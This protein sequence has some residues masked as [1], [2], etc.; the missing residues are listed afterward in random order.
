MGSIFSKLV[1]GVA[2]L[3][4]AT[5][6]SSS[7]AA[8]Q[9]NGPFDV[10]DEL[11]LT[12]EQ[13]RR[14]NIVSAAAITRTIVAHD[15]AIPIG[16]VPE[17]TSSTIAE[18][19]V[20]AL[21][22][23][24][25]GM[26]AYLVAPDDVQFMPNSPDGCTFRLDLPQSR[27]T[28]TNNLG[29][30]P[31]L[32]DDF[33]WIPDHWPTIR[34]R[35]ISFGQLGM[36]VIFHANTDVTLS[37]ESLSAGI[38]PLDES[39][40]TGP[41]FVPAG[42]HEVVWRAE[43]L[44]F[45]FF[46][47]ILPGAMM[48]LMMG[49][50][51]KFAKYLDDLVS[52]RAKQA[53]YI[54]G[55]AKENVPALIGTLKNLNRRINVVQFINKRLESPVGKLLG[56]GKKILSLDD[57]HD[58]F[59]VGFTTVERARTQGLTVYDIYQPTISTTE[60]IVDLEATD[61][62]GVTYARYAYDLA[63]TVEASDSC[64]RPIRISNDAPEFLPLGQTV[65][66]WTVSDPGPAIPGTDRDGDGLDD[67]V[68][69]NQI[70][71]TINVADTQAPI[72]VAPPGLV[73]ELAQGVSTPV[74]LASYD[75]GQPLVVDLVDLDPEVSNS[76]PDPDGQIEVD[77]RTVITWTTTDHAATP[78]VATAD[79]L[80]T[81]KSWNTN[82]PP[83]ADTNSVE[84]LTAKPVDIVL[85]ASDAD[86]LPYSHDPLGP[87]FPDPLQFKIESQPQNGEF[88]SP[89]LPFFINDY[90]TDEVGA[91]FD[92]ASNIAARRKLP[93][94]NPPTDDEIKAV[95]DD[96]IFA[97]NTNS[98]E[99]FLNNEFC[100][101]S[102]DAPLGFVWEPLYTQV[103]DN[104]EQYFF[105]QYLVCDP[106][107]NGDPEWASYY[108]ISRWGPGGDFMG[109]VRV[110]DNGGGGINNDEAVFDI[111]DEGF[112]YFVNS[113][114][115]GEAV[116][117]IQRCSAAL[118]SVAPNPG[119]CQSQGFG[120]VDADRVT[121]PDDSNWNPQNA[122]VDIDRELVYVIA[123][124]TIAVFDYRR[125]V[126]DNPNSPRR[127]SAILDW[128]TNDAG[129]RAVLD[130]GICAGPGNPRFR[131]TMEV[132]SQGN[133][134]VTDIE[135]HR[136][137]KFSP[138]AFDA[139]GVFVMGEYIGW[140]G[141]CNQS[142]NLACDVDEQRT[143]GFS[144]TIAAAC[145]VAGGIENGDAPGQF[146]TPAFLAIDPNDILYVADYD[147]SRIQRFGTDG[148]F[149]GQAVSTGNGINA[150][151]DGG[152]VLGNMGPPKHVSV[153]SKNFYV[154]D[155]SEDFVHVFDTSP[156]KN[157]SSS[158]ATVTYVS[159]FAFH[160]AIDT[161]TYS[162]N[163]GLVDSAVVQ[164]SIDVARNYRQ[165]QPIAQT[166]EALED[167]S[168]VIVLQGSDPDGIV[169][170]D[171]NGLDSL[172]FSISEQPEFG[173]LVRGGDPGD[174]T[175]DPGMDVWTYTPDSD[176]FG[177]DTLSFTVRD[178]FTDATDDGGTQIPEPYTEAEAAIV[179]INI[180]AVNDVPVV[181]LDPPERVAAGFPIMLDGTVFDDYGLDHTASVAWGDGT[182]DVLGE[183]LV[184]NNGTPNDSS[185]DS[186][187]FD[188]V[189]LNSESLI[190]IGRSRI[191][192]LHTYT[193]TGPRSIRTCVQDDGHLESCRSMEITVESLAM[194]GIEMTLDASDIKDGIVFRGAIEIAN[195]IPA[196]GVPGL[197][198]QNLVLEM[199]IPSEVVV[200][201]LNSPNGSCNIAASVL[202]CDFGT[203]ANGVVARVDLE[204]RGSGALFYDSEID[205]FAEVRTDT[206]SIEDV[207]ISG[208]T[209]TLRA[210]NLDRD[211][212]GMSNIFEGVTGVTEP[213]ADDDGDGL[214]NLEEFEAGTSPTDADSDGDG[215][216]DGDELN[217]F[218]SDPLE[219]DSDN[220]GISDSDE[221]NIYGSDPATSDTDGD[222]L[223]DNWEVDNGFDPLFADSNGD[224]DGDGLTDEDEYANETDYLNPDTDGDTLSD[225]DEVLVHN[226][227]PTLVD[228]DA[229]GL[230]DN[231]EIA[232]MTNPN[233]PDSDDDDLYD[234]TE[235]FITA[236]LPLVNDTDRDGLGD[237]YE[238][239]SGRNPLLA[240]Y[241]LA[242]GGLSTCALTDSGVECWGLDDF[243]QAPAVVAGLNDP[244]QIAVG[245][246]HACAI[247]RDTG[248]N[249]S[250]LCWG[251]NDFG[252]STAPALVDPVQIV[253][254][255]YHT[256]A[257]D[258]TAPDTT[259]V[260]CWGRNDTFSQTS[261]P[262]NIEQPLR[263]VA[264]ISGNSSC[265]LDDKQSGAELVCWG[266]YNNG[267]STLPSVGQNVQALAHGSEHGC[268]ID[269]GQQLCWGLND[270]GQAPPGP[271][272]KNAVELSLGGFHSC[273]LESI[274]HN[275]Y[276]VDCWGR[277]ADLQTD[278]PDNLTAPISL[279]SGSHH[280][281]SFDSG[282]ARCWGARVNWDRGQAP[283]TRSLDIDPDGDGLRSDAEI[284]AGT[285]PLDPDSDGDGLNDDV[286]I[287]LLTNPN[288]T[289]SDDDGLSDG[290]EVLTYQSDPLSDDT[291]GDGMDDEWEVDHGLLVAADD[292]A[293]DADGDG[294]DNGTEYA[295]GTDPT[296]A[297]TDDD[298]ID[299][300][301]ELQMALDPT[302]PDTDGDGTYDG[303]EVDNGFD[304]LD[305]ADSLLDTDGDGSTNFDEFVAG[306]NP[307]LIDT[308][309]DGMPDG[310]EID[311]DLDPLVTDADG[312]LD[313]DGLS[314]LDEY[315]SGA[316]A[317]AD[318][319][320][321][322]LT[323]PSDVL[324]DSIG[325][326]TNVNIGVAAAVDIR[327]GA[328]AATASDAGPFPPGPNDVTWSAAD[329]SGNRVEASQAVGVVPLVDFAIGQIVDEGDS[330]VVPIMLNGTAVD[331]PVQVN[332]SVLG[333]ATN[334][335]D[336][337]A[338]AGT[339]MI[340]SG[341]TA[342]IPVNIVLD[343]F[344]EGEESFTLSFVEIVNAVPGAQ[345]SHTVTITQSNVK[346]VATITATQRNNAIT[347][348]VSSQGPI[349]IT[350]TVSDPNTSDT[351]LLDWSASDSGIFDPAASTASSYV[352][353]PVTVNP[354]FYRIV[355]DIIDDGAPPAV[356]RIETLL[357]IVATAPPLDGGVDT[358]GDGIDDLT[359]GFD[360]SDNDRVPDYLDSNTH[361]ENVIPYAESS[362]V[363][364]TQPGLK[365]RLGE[366]AFRNGSVAGISEASVRE[367][368]DVGFPDLVAD[369]EVLGVE[370]GASALVVIPMRYALPGNA[371][372]RKFMGG[373][374]QDFVIDSDN[375][376]STAAGTN[377]ACPAPGDLVYTPGLNVG[378]G[379]IQVEIEDGG[380]NDTDGLANGIIRDPSGPAV[381][382]SVRL[383]ASPLADAASSR[384]SSNV[385]VLAFSLVSDSGDTE[386]SGLT[387]AASG[388]GDDMSV[389]AIRLV[390]DENQNG[391]VDN[392]EASIGEGVFQSDNGT[393]DIRMATPYTVAPGRT[394][395]LVTYD[396]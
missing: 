14:R 10:G 395:F 50:E 120:P 277:N 351:H 331:Y 143:K 74:N 221:V 245:F 85:T 134:Y 302:E 138:S 298:G 81:V 183:I 190:S 337:D 224:P 317:Y 119:Y 259:Q 4:L 99:T 16:F 198:A 362:F 284:A 262:G 27:T 17:P 150:N 388:S 206:P 213:D 25:K 112:V 71:Q 89:L 392:G 283:D 359:E 162:V 227:N 339:V 121:H 266:Q 320:P 61:I 130:D 78:N 107:G 52:G 380:P 165:P 314:N 218:G 149:A 166:V 286:E 157:I 290:A 45:P 330:I 174:I 282:A 300:A 301:T 62:G 306:T 231:D 391:I 324:A 1:L 167:R 148:L 127:S 318:D 373:G 385:V 147:N 151:I 123:G 60:P 341:V 333:S 168:V 340:E 185:D 353:D 343:P 356:N 199:E 12:E 366:T 36:P 310:W 255:E 261:V 83:L 354:G 287:Q 2:F 274:T 264:G 111:D 160:S 344:F 292:A 76:S 232:A 345:T 15:I 387:L 370:P 226:S 105:D 114:T 31:R 267:N 90:R 48:P 196:G 169:S 92:E 265:V 3:L 272:A 352:I 161:F 104:G 73:I 9:Y 42:N 367:D 37:L 66:T 219:T 250:V 197:D 241:G 233:K 79:Q 124:P 311:N 315:L 172:T 70:T 378:D 361:G 335:D 328:V 181:R 87:V 125:V 194:V 204:M 184:D 237:G 209:L 321:P 307:R 122:L 77:T 383:E 263:L 252:Q 65:V 59:G 43:T 191:N 365:L 349:V 140:M 82:T 97:V 347:T 228:T 152:F 214:S 135:C 34:D 304:P 268:L 88:E 322:V 229:D 58:R 5:T 316:S 39:Q 23:L 102:I 207:A 94:V 40:T 246:V 177:N 280:S 86:L 133:L 260:I 164:V 139:E 217:V 215:I 187:S 247:D 244:E 24:L 243:G 106:N 308:D 279:A 348:A 68:N 84:T 211:N 275:S 18:A 297:D 254:G 281:C 170:R 158:S 251:R 248:G 178:A 299:D 293:V 358:D 57:L 156:F 375:S 360:D 136:I 393:L 29:F 8:A 28:Y 69:T 374:W 238:D 240:D 257:L 188:G 56:L 35:P 234:G 113:R 202:V 216:S 289:D 273:A 115:G 80:V 305:D 30:T 384:G 110:D 193:S 7:P 201:Q 63:L 98:V 171:F 291:D 285:N 336:H 131:N 96:Y 159:E 364:Q 195:E 253:A 338:A 95:T 369:F 192:A 182:V 132:D 51:T 200:Q 372:Y 225:G 137:H 64:G 108:R 44:W 381:P 205:F 13:Q 271:L 38:I 210:I 276:A 176:H 355:V 332:Y 270:D 101:Y 239:L 118:T 319:V 175:L 146:F 249:R 145:T 179:S 295:E 91:I 342:G 126:P 256:C 154:V 129:N 100:D 329:L 309:G 288:D 363:L 303:W 55:S 396:F 109:H 325:P 142:N 258:R 47:T 394:D 312:D 203:L 33:L 67:L 212:D 20:L 230:D 222:G 6:M 278:V 186:I 49:V 208:A 386:L 223:P 72:I 180:A 54:M 242:A 32:G 117:S 19:S 326:F 93:D 269:A 144:C 173:T 53:K 41:Y 294:L 296:V 22:N 163:D 75:L 153:N 220:D 346:P 357:Q 189:I 116:L 235:V 155:Q 377:G 323:I 334:P 327:D 141:R 128:L 371:T 236:T 46:D 389:R 26:K 382:V 21:D 368:A 390:V 376:V 11:G 313:R 350:A 103:R 379:C